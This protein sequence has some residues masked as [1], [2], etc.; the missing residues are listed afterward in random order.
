MEWRVAPRAVAPQAGQTKPGR[1]EALVLGDIGNELEGESTKGSGSMSSME[2]AI[3]LNP[4]TRASATLHDPTSRA[5]LLRASQIRAN[6]GLLEV[7]REATESFTLPEDGKDADVR[8]DAHHH[9][10]ELSSIKFVD[11]NAVADVDTAYA[12]EDVSSSDGFVLGSIPRT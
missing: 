10:S 5:G 6:S 3:S 9:L 4:T 2:D 12:Y 11:A 7:P 1:W 8:T